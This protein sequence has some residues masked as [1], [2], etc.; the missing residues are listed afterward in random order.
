MLSRGPGAWAA[1]FPWSIIPLIIG[2]V[3]KP[4]TLSAGSYVVAALTF[5]VGIAATI[6]QLR[7]ADNAQ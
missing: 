1:W 6:A 3:D 2:A 4:Q 7:Y 5:V